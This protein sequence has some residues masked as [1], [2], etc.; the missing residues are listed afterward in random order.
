MYGR[1]V[2]RRF[3]YAEV[4][5]T[6]AFFV[7]VGGVGWAA[8]TVNSGDVVNNSLKSKDLKDDKAVKSA[9]VPLNALTGEDIDEE[10]LQDVDARR[11][12]GRN[13]DNYPHA[14]SRR[15]RVSFG[16]APVVL[17]LDD[18][19]GSTE[20]GNFQLICENPS[21]A[22]D[23]VLRFLPP[24]TTGLMGPMD[25]WVSVDGGPTT[26]EEVD[27][28]A[29]DPADQMHEVELVP[30]EHHRV[31][32]QVSP[33]TTAIGPPDPDGFVVTATFSYH[34]ADAAGAVCEVLGQAT[35]QRV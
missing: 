8:A 12:G 14:V 6:L 16:F 15:T 7:A 26:Y 29:P 1:S 21:D 3:G 19:Q 24:P 35:V 20:A 13:S 10:T 2:R 28:D 5:S 18:P 30:G 17:A 31:V 23:S 22:D 33:V 4:M 25:S 9:D 27:P 34:Q 11:L 32:W